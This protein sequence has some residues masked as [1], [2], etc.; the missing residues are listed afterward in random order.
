MPLKYFNHNSYRRKQTT[1]DNVK[2]AE[3]Q[4]QNHKIPEH[5]FHSNQGQHKVNEPITQLTGQCLVDL[6]LVV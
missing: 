1:K 5:F 3:R 4:I 2:S 6:P